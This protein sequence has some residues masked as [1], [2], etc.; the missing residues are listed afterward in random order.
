LHVYGTATGIGESGEIQ[1]HGWGKRLMTEAENIACKNGKDKIVV[2]SGVGVR[3]Y[4][5]KLGYK[6]EGPYMAKSFK[7]SRKVYK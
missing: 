5:R 7:P 1:H 6:L 2:I 3:E 4:Y